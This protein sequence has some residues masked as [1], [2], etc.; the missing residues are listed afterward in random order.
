MK[1]INLPSLSS[2]GENAFRGNQ[3]LEYVNLSSLTN[4]DAYGV[5]YGFGNYDKPVNGMDFSKVTYCGKHS[6]ANFRATELN[7]S[8][9]S[10]SNTTPFQ[11]VD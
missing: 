3:D 8:S 10:S 1:E 11:I 9:L 5:F 7:L 4:F 2:V 6:F